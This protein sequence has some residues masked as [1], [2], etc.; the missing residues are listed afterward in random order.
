MISWIGSRRTRAPWWT[1]EDEAS[2]RKIWTE[3]LPD[4]AKAKL[5]TDECLVGMAAQR[6]DWQGICLRPGILRDEGATGKV[7]LGRTPARGESWSE[8]CFRAS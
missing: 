4:Y 7:L 2:N 1:D 6:K 5:D 8:H 3:V